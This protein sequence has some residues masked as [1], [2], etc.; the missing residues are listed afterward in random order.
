MFGLHWGLVPIAMNNIAVLGYDPVVAA[1]MAVCFAQTG[2][3][4]AILM[5]TKNK[6]LKSLIAV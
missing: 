4:L 3:V 1:S 6:K 2:V 5:K